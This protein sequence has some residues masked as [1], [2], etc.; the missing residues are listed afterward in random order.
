MG[1]GGED[2]V[3]L[4]LPL[5]LSTATAL[6]AIWIGQR[7]RRQDARR[8]FVEFAIK[9]RADVSASLL[10]AMTQRV[11]LV[12]EAARW[13][14]EA[15][16]SSDPKIQAL[17]KEKMLK[18]LG[19]PIEQNT[20]RMNDAWAAAHTVFSRDVL[21]PGEEVVRLT[22]EAAMDPARFERERATEALVGLS[23]A[24][25]AELRLPEVLR[26]QEDLFREPWPQRVLRRKRVTSR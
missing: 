7:G 1:S 15:T 17:G 4:W 13:R 2:T 22:N 16:A 24:L 9:Q 26:Y 8:V 18:I 12:D 19:D 5:A 23:E 21:K 20:I 11:Q 10:G 14:K 25:R 3:R 6:F